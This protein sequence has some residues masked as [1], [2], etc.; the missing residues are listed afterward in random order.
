L[1]RRYTADRASASETRKAGA[2]ALPPPDP[3][4]VFAQ[5]TRRAILL[6]VSAIGFLHTAAVHV[7]A[8][9]ALVDEFDSARGHEHVVRPELLDRARRSG[10][11]DGDLAT[12]IDEALV[13]LRRRGA[14]V[15]LCTCSTL[16]AV[17]EALGEGFGVVVLRVDRPMAELA[18]RGGPRIAVVAA[19][20]SALAPT[21][22]LLF[23]VARGAGIEVTLVD[24]ACF[25][26]WHHFESGELEVYHRAVAACVDALDAR[27]DTVVLAQASMAPALAYVQTER[28]V[29]SSPRTAVEAALRIGL[30]ARSFFST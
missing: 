25:D 14:G 11:D 22:S 2:E 13:E 6:R 7:D 29:L 28:V 8:F 4:R 9:G 16:G 5:P 18:V 12:G 15:V 21:R 1:R 17:A 30:P 24:G 23:E 26:A 19:L 20:E 3:E 10:A 27:V